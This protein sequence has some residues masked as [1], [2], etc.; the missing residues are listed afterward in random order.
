[1]KIMVHMQLD[2][3]LV[4]HTVR[5]HWSF[6]NSQLK[7]IV[8]KELKRMHILVHQIKNSE[9]LCNGAQTTASLRPQGM[10]LEL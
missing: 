10:I 1:M 3:V 7:A 2:A 6:L 5:N 8:F 4:V 9:L